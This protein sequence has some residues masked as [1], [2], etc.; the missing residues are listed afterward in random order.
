M[1]SHSSRNRE[2]PVTI[3]PK[4]ARSNRRTTGLKPGV[5]AKPSGQK[6]F[7]FARFL[8]GV[9]RTMLFLFLFAE[10][11]GILSP[12]GI[13][14]RGSVFAEGGETVPE[15]KIKAEAYLL[16]L[17][18]SDQILA[19]KNA[20]KIM[21]P[22]STT[23]I[24]TAL[25]VLE[26]VKNLDEIVTIDEKS[27]FIEG[28]KLFISVG[29][30]FT[31]RD[32]LHAL[33]IVS[34]NDVASAL[35]IHVA[36]GIDE[37]SL[38]MNDKAQELGCKNTNFV[39]PHGLHESLHYT[40]AN[41][42]YLIAKAAMDHPEFAEIVGKA[43]YVIEPTNMQPEQR[44]LYNTN[45]LLKDAYLSYEIR[46]DLYGNPTETYFDYA[47]GIKTGFTEEAGH[48]LVSSATLNHNTVYAVVLNSEYGK[49][50]E[51]SAK[52][53][54]YG[55]FGFQDYVLKKA[56]EVV[57]K[58]ELRDS[59]KT[60]VEAVPQFPLTTMLKSPPKE[61]E[62]RYVT[63]FKKNIGL[64]IKTGEPI[65]TLEAFLGDISLGSVT[66][67]ANADISGK[68]LLDDQIRHF[69]RESPFPIWA[70]IFFVA[71]VGVT[72]FFV[73]LLAY[74]IGLHPNSPKWK[75][76][77]RNKMMKQEKNLRSDME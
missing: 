73:T 13:L 67:I 11:I 39:S 77:R 56:D 57:A 30:Q 4:S 35:A 15:P 58:Y 53:L 41:D 10:A 43:T 76:R 66:L 26:H 2:F 23:K 28:S 62:I 54:E 29:E 55:L 68:P 44:E 71:E 12:G 42:L 60:A 52:L 65:G 48:C 75:K 36:G 5:F 24:M 51:D 50:F 9:L 46:E 40:T 27:P 16:V 37:F 63:T 20:D 31:V 8:R 1:N 38:M 64:P 33:L 72:F 3:L 45:A 21:F 17:R 18:N 6:T 22:A 59:Q 49:V 69:E 7:V 70:V 32:L 74:L 61:D 34:G 47:N 25:V 14:P 19:S